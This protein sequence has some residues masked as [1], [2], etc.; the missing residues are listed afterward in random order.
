MVS[1]SSEEIPGTVLRR[2]PIF[3]RALKER[4]ALSGAFEVKVR[5]NADSN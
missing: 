4:L 5:E 2:L 3:G 1:S